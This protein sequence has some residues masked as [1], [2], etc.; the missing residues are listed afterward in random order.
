[1]R[2]LWLLA[3]PLGVMKTVVFNDTRFDSSGTW[4]D[5]AL[6]SLAA[7]GVCDEVFVMSIDERGDGM[8]HEG[9][10]A[11]YCCLKHERVN[12]YRKIDYRLVEQMRTVIDSLSPDIVHIFGTETPFTMHSI[13]AVDSRYPW[14]IQIQGII[15]VI[16]RYQFGYISSKDMF[17][18]N[19]LH[20][21]IGEIWKRRNVNRVAE[22]MEIEAIKRATSII[23]GTKWGSDICNY[24]QANATIYNVP[25]AINDVFQNACWSIED[26]ERGR[27]LT[28]SEN[29]GF[30]G[31]HQVIHAVASLVNQHPNIKIVVPGRKYDLNAK[32]SFRTNPY[33]RYLVRLCELY[34]MKDHIEFLGV[35]SP[36]EMANEIKKANVF[37]MGSAIENE[38]A[39]LR[40]AMYV[41]A[42]CIASNVGSI[43]E[44]ITDGVDGALYRY[45][46]Y[47]RM[48]IKIKRILEDDL[49]AQQYSEN[50]RKTI[51]AKFVQGR[52]AGKIL[53]KT[54]EDIMV[55]YNR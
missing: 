22:V 14:C 15:S 19:P 2:V 18:N 29:N 46:E 52:E 42:P 50:G 48:A 16:N 11:Q 1:M 28:I 8:W 45:E 6:R 44:I 31:L 30:K 54:Y 12:R 17:G 40:E 55:R 10:F 24:Y 32:I 13:I 7:C 39:A 4:I 25:L 53:L 27:I 47:E 49:L 41:G 23:C 20:R 43:S 37:V 35:L 5:N 3:A 9:E 51:R 26:C 36:M 21:T 34:N 38:S 33:L